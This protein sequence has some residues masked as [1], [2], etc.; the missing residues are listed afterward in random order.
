MGLTWYV[1]IMYWYYY[2][3]ACGVRLSYD[4]IITQVQI[5]QMVIGV[6]TSSIWSYYYF[7]SAT[8]CP[9]K[10]PYPMIAASVIMYGT[11]LYLFGSFYVNRYLKKKEEA[12]KKS[13]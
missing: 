6:I 12:A 4:Q 8:S 1:Q 13:S 11:Y 5:F 2:R 9:A 10:Y 7:Q 3:S